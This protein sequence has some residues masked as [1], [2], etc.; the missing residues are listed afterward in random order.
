MGTRS[1][2]APHSP[3]EWIAGFAIASRVVDKCRASPWRERWA[4]TIV[5][6]IF[7]E[8]WIDVALARARRVHLQIARCTESARAACNGFPSQAF[9]A[10]GATAT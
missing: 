8:Q 7:T 4:N 9:T 5:R 10:G 6:W 2:E 3:R 1:K